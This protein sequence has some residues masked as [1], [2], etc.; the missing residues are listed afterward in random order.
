[1]IKLTSVVCLLASKFS[2]QSVGCQ[3]PL[4]PDEDCTEQSGTSLNG[5]SSDDDSAT[6]SGVP[7]NGPDG[8][9]VPSCI[10]NGDTATERAWARVYD[11]ESISSASFSGSYLVK[12]VPYVR[13]CRSQ[14][15]SA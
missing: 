9:N 6:T 4:N 7:A 12:T 5:A 3:W 10:I 8:I 14:L 2:K 13:Q 1:M 11:V 15:W